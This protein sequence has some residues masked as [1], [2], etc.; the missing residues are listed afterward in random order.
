MKIE[1]I[2]KTLYKTSIRLKKFIIMCAVLVISVPVMAKGDDGEGIHLFMLTG[3]DNMIS[4]D[5]NK[6]FVPSIKKALGSD[7][8]VVVKLAYARKGIA[9]WSRSWECPEGDTA[10]KNDYAGQSKGWIFHELS[11]KVRA[12]VGDKKVK[13]LSLIWIQGESDALGLAI[14]YG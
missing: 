1:I 13:T 6:V 10:R 12:A 14:C 9:H 4:M 11:E 5:E 8:V 7:K 2:R 3:E